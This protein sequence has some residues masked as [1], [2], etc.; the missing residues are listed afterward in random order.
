MNISPVNNFKYAYTFKSNNPEQDK[1]E[2]SKTD[3]AEESAVKTEDINNKTEKKERTFNK[4]EV[5]GIAA[6]SALSAAVIG[7]TLI[8]HGRIK[9]LTRY[10]DDLTQL[11]NSLKRELQDFK[12]RLNTIFDGDINPTDADSSFVTRIKQKIDGKRI[13]YDTLVPPSSSSDFVK[14][15]DAIPLP[16]NVGTNNRAMNAIL[17]IPEVGVDGSFRFEIPKSVE[18]QVRKVESREFTPIR[19][20]AT[21][22][23]EGYADS[24]QWNN[25]KIARDILQN[26]YDGHGQT[27]DGVKLDFTPIE[28]GRYR[29][30]ISGESTYTADKALY[31]GESTKRDDVRAAG[32]YGEGLK[33]AALKLLKDGG[34]QN[35]R[36]ASDN[37]QLTYSLGNSELSDSRVLMYSLD[38]VNKFDGNFIEFETRDKGLLDSFKASIN[39]FYHSGNPHFIKPDFENELVG[40]KMLSANEKGGIYI[41]GQRFEFDND[42]DGLKNTVIFLK[43]KLPV[44]VL[45]PSRDRT[46][47]NRS[48]LGKIANWL[49]AQDR[50]PKEDC[51]KLL[52][53]FEPYWEKVNYSEMKPQDEFVESFIT[54][55]RYMISTKPVHID[56]SSKYVA[57]SRASQA[58]VDELRDKGY[59][60]CKEG[61]S[62]L[63][64][65]TIGQLMGG[66]RAHNP[67][68]PTEVQ[69]KK[70]VILKE[71]LSK[72]QNLVKKGHFSTEELDTKIYIFDKTAAGE[73][74]LYTDTLAE[75]ILDK[76]TSK[77]FWIDKG[78][79]DRAS[80]SDVLETALHELSHKA[81]G[82]GSAQFSY[83]LTNVNRDAID[84]I[85]GDGMVRRELQVLADMW[86]DLGVH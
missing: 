45:D 15:D 78:Y 38:K 6:A 11:N 82:D 75:A 86:S 63:G 13:E 74:H 51:V 21:N 54:Q 49:A 29:V 65:Q 2:N 48:Q 60:I 62:G 12:N 42:Y 4:K 20:Q 79:L 73:S 46:S 28:G 57:Y 18:T 26:F 16:E 85:L 53:A 40:I 37:W 47:L 8:G 76:F 83:K 1:I 30:R 80:F 56:F 61:F 77:G 24:V 67:I 58:L 10:N 41:A 39:R 64:M 69:S 14:F 32:N 33:M 19:N 71:A 44:S 31:I 66:A 84:Q 27:L 7:G 59:V 70:I 5:I 68:A 55:L 43:E 17:N 36:Y 72:L 25:D 34:A 50:M 22:I 9:R 3:N 52:K 35:V 23:T 81:G